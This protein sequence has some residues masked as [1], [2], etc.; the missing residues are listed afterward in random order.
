MSHQ[1]VFVMDVEILNTPL[2]EIECEALMIPTSSQGLMN[3]SPGKTIKTIGGQKI[4][5]EIVDIAPI[6]IGAAAVTGSGKMKKIKQII[7]VPNRIKP[8]E[9]ARIENVRI[10]VHAA[11]VAANHLEIDS[12]AIPDPGPCANYI[13]NK[14]IARALVDEV[15]NFKEKYPAKVILVSENKQIFKEL[16][17]FA[18][19]K[20]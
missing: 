15:R 5:D 11:L 3:Q 7:H 14:E 18:F 4:E 2:K 8:E 19:P 13:R 6:A 16:N 17:S 10:S 9:T 20:K 1:A 12:L